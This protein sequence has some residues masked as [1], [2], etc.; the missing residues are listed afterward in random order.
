MPFLVCICNNRCK[1]KEESIS[2]E[3]ISVNS[4]LASIADIDDI[5]HSNQQSLCH[6]RHSPF[7]FNCFMPSL[8]L[9]VYANQIDSDFYLTF[10]IATS[11]V[12]KSSDIQ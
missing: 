8:L 7:L 9:L 1:Q 2:V 3:S 10:L 6:P 4:T 11:V 12:Y 5:A